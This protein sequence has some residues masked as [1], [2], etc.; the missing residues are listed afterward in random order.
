M[1]ESTH[2]FRTGD[3]VK[4]N[5]SG[6]TWVLAWGNEQEVIACGWPETVAKPSDCTLVV[7]AT[8]EAHRK[9]VLE[10]AGKRNDDLRKSRCWDLVE[11][12][13]A[14]ECRSMM[15]S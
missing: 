12:W 8:D 7:A 5:P 3:V 15:T 1:P 6:E 11:K 4:H 2:V 13:R 14:E 10:I 9:L